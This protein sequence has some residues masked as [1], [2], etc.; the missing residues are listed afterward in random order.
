MK[1]LVSAIIPN[2]NYARYVGEAVESALAQTYPNIEV[3]VVDDGSTDN[4]LE[5]LER[6]QG[7]IKLI[8]QK[9]SGVCVA[10]NRGV[11]ESTGEYIAFLDAD[12]V[13]LP[14]KLSVQMQG[15]QASTKAVFSNCG[16]RL[17][18]LDGECVG[19]LTEGK[20]GDVSTYL[21]SFDGPAV[22]GAAST[23]I[24]SRKV[25]ESVGGFDPRLSTAADWDFCFRVAQ[26]GEF[27][28]EPQ[29]LVNYRIHGTNMHGNIR[30]MEQDMLLCFEKA[31]AKE[32]SHRDK[33]N[34]YYGNLFRVLSGS[35]FRGG[36]Y[37]DFLRTAAKSLWYRP[38]GIGY[39]AAFPLRKL[40]G[41]RRR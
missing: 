32:G 4:S 40:S 10:R 9:N 26:L 15:F 5:V 12:D 21:L 3:I 6:Y 19:T 24:V 25:F 7:R 31:F 17:I 38:S 11:E 2:Y 27:I 22:V 8:Q 13:W 35:Y 33:R 28:F 1:P 16:M 41:G 29:I 39:F 14:E 30:V 36:E 23:G 34:V 37:V 18:D 20:S